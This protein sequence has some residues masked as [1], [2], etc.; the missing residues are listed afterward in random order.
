MS[1][2]TVVLNGAVGNGIVVR[3]LVKTYT[4]A[5]TDKDPM[6]LKGIKNT[7]RAVDGLNLTVPHNQIFC[8][9]GPV[10]I[11]PLPLHEII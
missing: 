5:Y 10:R 8:L 11:R 3:D 1:S 2:A 9:L 6:G 7:I 4:V